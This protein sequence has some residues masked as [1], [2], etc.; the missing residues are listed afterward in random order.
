MVIFTQLAWT[1]A[2]A[3]VAGFGAAI[4]WRKGNQACEALDRA[5]SAVSA[6]I[7][8]QVDRTAARLQGQQS[9]SVDAEPAAA[10]P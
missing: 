2:T 5:S 4:G 9:G 3:V 10:A 7:K 6:S 8:E 1:L